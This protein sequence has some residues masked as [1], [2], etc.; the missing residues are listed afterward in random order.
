MGRMYF[1]RERQKRRLAEGIH[2][3]AMGSRAKPS[4]VR[5]QIRDLLGD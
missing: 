2:A 4:D 3:S 1:E 5:K